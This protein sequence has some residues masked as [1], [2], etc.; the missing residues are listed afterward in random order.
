MGRLSTAGKSGAPHVIPVCFALDES[1]AGVAIYIALDQKPKSAELTRP[2]A[3][4][5]HP[6][7]PAGGL[8]GG[9]L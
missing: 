2:E 6:G 3:R 9:P 1:E 7:K 4:P 5:Q 8:G